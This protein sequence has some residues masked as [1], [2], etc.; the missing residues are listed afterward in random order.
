MIVGTKEF[1]GK[2]AREE[3]AKALTYA[4]LTWRDDFTLQQRASFRG[5]QILSRGK[6]LTGLAFDGETLPELSIRGAGLYSAIR[7]QLLGHPNDS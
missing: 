1:S 3:A 6:R 5:F 2:G 4:V 7:H